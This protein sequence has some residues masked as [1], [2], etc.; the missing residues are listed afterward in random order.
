MAEVLMLTQ[1]FFVSY[2]HDDAHV[3]EPIVAMLR[4]TGTTVFRDK[5]SIQPGDKW[6]QVLN[7]SLQ[8][9]DVFLVF[10]SGNSAASEEVRTEYESALAMDTRI[11]PVLLDDTP[12]DAALAQYQHIDFRPAYRSAACNLGSKAT[13]AQIFVAKLLIHLQDLAPRVG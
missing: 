3:V 13:A 7:Q 8:Q 10:W 5:D 1:I 12:I 11:V 2:S 6:R 4:T 9:A